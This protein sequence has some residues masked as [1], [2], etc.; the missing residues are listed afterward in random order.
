MKN[1]L[2]GRK[3]LSCSF[4]LYRVRKYVFY[5][6]PIINFCNLGVHYKTPCITQILVCARRP[7]PLCLWVCFWCNSPT[8]GQGLLIHEVS[9]SQATTHH[10]RLDSSGRVISPI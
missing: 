10:S 9:R 5:G 4:Y 2:L 1:N 3:F 7:S 8:V 6:F